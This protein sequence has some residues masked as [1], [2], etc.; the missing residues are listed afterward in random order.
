MIV[1]LAFYLFSGEPRKNYDDAHL[2]SV[3]FVFVFSPLLPLGVF[4]VILPKSGRA[5]SYFLLKLA[6]DV[7]DK[8]AI[9]NW[10]SQLDQNF[11]AEF[12]SNRLRIPFQTQPHVRTRNLLLRLKRN[13]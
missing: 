8:V 2:D 6:R 9:Y 5:V 13:S 10:V 12:N 3:S 1:A 7:F 11:E 4:A